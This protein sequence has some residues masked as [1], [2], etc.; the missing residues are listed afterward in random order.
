[1][2]GDTI[3]LAAVSRHCSLAEEKDAVD[4]VAT[5]R[6][7]EGSAFSFWRIK[8]VNRS[9]VWGLWEVWFPQIRVGGEE[10]WAAYPSGWGVLMPIS[11]QPFSFQSVYPSGSC[12][13]Q[14]GSFNTGNSG[15]YY[16]A[17]DGRAST[18]KL[19]FVCDGAGSDLRMSLGQY[20]EGMGIPARTYEQPYDAVIGEFKGDS[21]AR[22]RSTAN[23]R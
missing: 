10:G 15:I 19:A 23:G 18:K 16:A 9:K 14:F 7:H 11:G 13:M 2:A 4:I 8:V 22:A 17:H 1:M 6:I 12:A 5:V 21:V 3:A 20:P